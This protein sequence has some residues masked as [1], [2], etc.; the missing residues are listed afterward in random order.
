MIM[1]TRV[2]AFLGLAFFLAACG[3]PEDSPSRSQAP[4]ATPDAVSEAK[5]PAVARPPLEKPSPKAI[6]IG[7]IKSEPLPPSSPSVRKGSPSLPSLSREDQLL[8]EAMNQVRAEYCV[9]SDPKAH[10]FCQTHGY[11]PI[12]EPLA[13]SVRLTQSARWYAQDMAGLPGEVWAKHEDSK[14]RNFKARLGFFEYPYRAGENI[15]QVSVQGGASDGSDLPLLGAYKMLQGWIGSA[16]HLTNL[17]NPRF[18][19]VGIGHFCADIYYEKVSRALY[20][21]FWVTD[22]GFYLE[23]V[24]D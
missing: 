15:G 3:K 5:T 13:V 23:E 19:T 18:K 8:L 9:R 14:S 7:E 22:F 10:E 6:L 11:R 17:L 16:S 21:C 24:L 12:Q 2:F 4:N 20:S 1:G